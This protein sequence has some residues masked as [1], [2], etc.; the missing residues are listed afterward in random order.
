V[1]RLPSLF[2]EAPTSLRLNATP[3]PSPPSWPHPA[4]SHWPDWPSGPAPGR[5]CNQP[6][7]ESETVRAPRGPWPDTAD[8]AAR[9]AL[10]RFQ[11]PSG[12]E[13]RR[14]YVSDLWPPARPARPGEPGDLPSRRCAGAEPG[15]SAESTA[16]TGWPFNVCAEPPD[17]ERHGGVGPPVCPAQGPRQDRIVVTQCRTGGGPDSEGDRDRADSDH[18]AT[19]GC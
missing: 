6:G 18:G 8:A 16:R 3:A 12:V 11:E 13:K 14:S 4:S 10:V 5:G 17:S 9:P 19:N 2:T 7:L 1:E 15:P